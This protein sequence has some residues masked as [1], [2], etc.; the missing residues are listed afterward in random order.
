MPVR[1]VGV[2]QG[3]RRTADCVEIRDMLPEAGTLRGVR[4]PEFNI[5]TSTV[6]PSLS[7]VHYFCERTLRL[8]GG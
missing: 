1:Q 2:L 7:H 4:R 5:P 6:N 3:D 8:L